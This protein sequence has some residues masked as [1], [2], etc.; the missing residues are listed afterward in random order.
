MVAPPKFKNSGQN[1]I[2]RIVP[3]PIKEYKTSYKRYRMT[4]VNETTPE[5]KSGNGI[6]KKIILQ[7]GHLARSLNQSLWQ[8][9]FIEPADRSV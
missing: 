3:A 6:R 4:G 8:S 9:Q 5:L 7:P 1:T 2:Q